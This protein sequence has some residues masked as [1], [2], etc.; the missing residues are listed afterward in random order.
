MLDLDR[1]IP[2]LNRAIAESQIEDFERLYPGP[3]KL[4]GFQPFP[5]ERYGLKPGEYLEYKPNKWK[6]KANARSL[7]DLIH[8]HTK[9]YA[10][11]QDAYDEVCDHFGDMPVPRMKVYVTDR[12]GKRIYVDSQVMEKARRLIIASTP[13]KPKS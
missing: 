11:I 1:N 12:T 6:P 13:H 9:H 7:D 3:Y 4:E 10:H 8:R 2:F 5:P